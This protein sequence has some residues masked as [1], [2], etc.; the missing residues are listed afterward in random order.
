[1]PAAFIPVFAAVAGSLVSS[2]LAP[3]PEQQQQVAAAPTASGAEADKAGLA[4]QQ[5]Q[6]AAA[7][8]AVG[9]GDTILTGPSGLGD[10]AS[11]AGYAPKKTI[12][13][14]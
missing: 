10:T 12:L 1:M 6:R 5:R 2:M 11:D 9:R 4:A 7:V 14:A 8:A 13:G 3:K